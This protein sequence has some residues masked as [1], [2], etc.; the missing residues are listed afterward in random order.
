M[1]VIDIFN[2]RRGVYQIGI[3]NTSTSPNGCAVD[4]SPNSNDIFVYKYGFIVD[5]KIPNYIGEVIHKQSDCGLKLVGSVFSD[6][7]SKNLLSFDERVFSKYSIYVSINRKVLIEEILVYKNNSGVYDIGLNS[8]SGSKRIVNL[9]GNTTLI[10]KDE[11]PSFLNSIFSNILNF[12]GLEDL[13][14]K[15]KKSREVMDF[16]RLAEAIG[17]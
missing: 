16:L 14:S 4:Y 12:N 9:L 8:L 5:G 15:R 13:L 7:F 6:I 17:F 3:I 11:F 2:S 10:K 1:L